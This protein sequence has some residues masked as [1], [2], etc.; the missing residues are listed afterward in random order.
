MKVLYSTSTIALSQYVVQVESTCGLARQ[1][2]RWVRSESIRR[3]LTDPVQTNV[4]DLFPPYG[5]YPK[6]V[7][8]GLNEDWLP[9]QLQALGYNTYYTGKLFNHHT[10]DNYHSPYVK[11]FNGSDFL[12]DPYTYEYYRMPICQ[13]Y[14]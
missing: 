1:L 6:F 4:T 3:A 10:V 7:E 5:G 2:I 9:T 8:V 12:L 14:S 13:A 11:G